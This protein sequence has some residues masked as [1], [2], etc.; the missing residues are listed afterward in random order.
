MPMKN[1]LFGCT[2]SASASAPPAGAM[3]PVS[4]GFRSFS[5]P[6]AASGQNHTAHFTVMGLGPP[7]GSPDA[8]PD[9]PSS[10][11]QR[12]MQIELN[13][14]DLVDFALQVATGME[15]MASKNAMHYLSTILFLVR[16]IV[17]YR[18]IEFT[19]VQ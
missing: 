18:C 10:L 14:K 15:F 17:F 4:E 16:V 1:F 11:E 19:T 5:K 12:N 6:F 9:S 13:L 8:G 3:S 2:A 7:L